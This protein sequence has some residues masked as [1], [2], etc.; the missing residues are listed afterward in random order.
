V[1]FTLEPPAADEVL[2]CGPTTPAPPAPGRTAAWPGRRRIAD[3][4]PGPRR[5]AA[6][7]RSRF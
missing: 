2:P 6:G 7:R 3:W 4:R 1:D 5:Q